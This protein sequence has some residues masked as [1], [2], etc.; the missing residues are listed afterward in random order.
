[1]ATGAAGAAGALALPSTSAPGT[2]PQRGRG[3]AAPTTNP[4]SIA[5]LEDITGIPFVFARHPIYHEAHIH[6]NN[7]YSDAFMDM[8]DLFAV[9]DPLL[10]SPILL[11]LSRTRFEMNLS[12]RMQLIHQI[13]IAPLWARCS[14]SISAGNRY[15]N[16]RLTPATLKEAMQCAIACHLKHELKITVGIQALHF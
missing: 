6:M 4:R 11:W 1:M 8:E 2:A 7:V 12:S 10:L 16:R 14:F 13:H 15:T 9:T 5:D 3:P